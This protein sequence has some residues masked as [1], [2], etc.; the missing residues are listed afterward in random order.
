MK[1]FAHIQEVQVF[2]KSI[3][4]IDDI[5]KGV[6]SGINQFTKPF[7][8][9]QKKFPSKSHDLTAVFSRDKEYL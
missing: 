7:M 3:P 5:V 6:K 2:F 1:K 4:F 8:Y 9:N